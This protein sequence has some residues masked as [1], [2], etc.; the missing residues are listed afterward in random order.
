MAAER[1]PSIPPD[2]SLVPDVIF[3]RENLKR[4]VGQMNE[5][6]QVRRDMLLVLEDMRDLLIQIRDKS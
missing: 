4:L 2:D 3:V 5:D 6:A 1:A